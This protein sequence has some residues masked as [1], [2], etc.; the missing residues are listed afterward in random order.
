MND[1]S[2]AVPAG[3]L[4]EILD[5]HG[6]WLKSAKARGKRAD[7]RGADLQKAN[8]AG[9]SLEAADLRGTDFRDADLGNA[10]LRR[11]NLFKVV[12]DRANLIGADL[13]G[14]QFL[15]CA[16]LVTAR[17]WQRAFRDEDLA[18]GAGIPERPGGG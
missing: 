15:S 17:G 5:A 3:A 8:L 10:D 6:Q 13:A 12:L 11:A 7:L 18:C 1:R 9:A 4:R 2:S 16:Q 14:A